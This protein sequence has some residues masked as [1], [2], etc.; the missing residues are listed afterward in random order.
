MIYPQH[1]IITT[2]QKQ[3][4]AKNIKKKTKLLIEFHA[5]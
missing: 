2:I 4:I 3:K 5:S 1:Q